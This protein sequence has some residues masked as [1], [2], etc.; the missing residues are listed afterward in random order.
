MKLLICLPI[1]NEE[2]VLEKNIKILVNFLE[3]KNLGFSWK[4]VLTINGSSDNSIGV[5]KKLSKNYKKINYLEVK[6]PGKGRAIKHCF[7][8][9]NDKDILMYMDADLAVSMD[10][11]GDLISPIINENYEFVIASR[12]LKDSKSKRSLIRSIL[13]RLY[14]LLSKLFFNHKINDLQCGY[15]A[16]KKRAYKT[17]R[18]H[19]KDDYWFF[20][21]EWLV[22]SQFF[23]LRIKEIP[24]DWQENRYNKRKSTIKT[25]SVSWQFII[26]L[27]KLKIRMIKMK[28]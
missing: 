23:K 26:N 17:I 9:N 11:L 14:N 8:N 6:K 28:N 22:L 2:K 15:K 12:T 27:I 24:V 25:F 13:S 1:R 20:D 4:I 19:L 16:I 10:N 21:T 7:D 5:A 3:K 18:P